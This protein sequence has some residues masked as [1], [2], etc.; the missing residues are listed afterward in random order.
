VPRLSFE[1]NEAATPQPVD[2]CAG[3]GV[4]D[5]EPSAGSQ[6]GPRQEGALAP[7][8]AHRSDSESPSAPTE[9]MTSVVSMRA[10]DAEM[11]AR[12]AAAP[13]VLTRSRRFF[14]CRQA[15]TGTEANASLTSHSAMSESG[16]ASAF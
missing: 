14:I 7:G 12:A 11:D 2:V 3:F 13:L 8:R 4:Q 10:P 6:L 1:R 15:A 16:H 5:H 9:L